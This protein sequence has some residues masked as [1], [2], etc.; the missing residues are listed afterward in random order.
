MNGKIA[1]G[2]VESPIEEGTPRLRPRPTGYV[3]WLSEVK[4]PGFGRSAHGVPGHEGLFPG[5]SHV[6]AGIRRGLGR[7][8]DCPTGCWTNPVGA[9][10]GAYGE[11]QEPRF[12]P[13]L[14]CEHA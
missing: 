13:C 9:Q 2:K 12:A 3:E 5:E 4:A 6:Y 14:R 11:A 10:P 1:K 7:A 8:R